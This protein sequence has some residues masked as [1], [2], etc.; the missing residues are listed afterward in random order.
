MSF[1]GEPWWCSS[2]DVHDEIAVS[3]D[4]G[5]ATRTDDDG[6]FDLLDDGRALDFDVLRQSI[7]VVDRGGNE[8]LRLVEIDRTVSPQCVRPGACDGLGRGFRGRALGAA[9]AQ[10]HR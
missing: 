6:R 8:A 5:R 7:I 9:C 10:Y 3:I 1:V 2:L 4:M